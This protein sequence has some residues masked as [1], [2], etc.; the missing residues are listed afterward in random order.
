MSS[1]SAPPPQS[2]IEPGSRLDRYELLCVLAHGGMANVWLARVQGKLGF[3]KFFAVKTILPNV[4]E[5]P[6]FKD[7]FLDEARIASR[8]EHPNVVHISDVG[9]FANVPYLVMDLVEGEPLYKLP[10][11]CEKANT[12]LPLGIV[13]RI[14]ADACH[15]LHAAHEL[16]DDAGNLLNVVHRDMSPQ[17]ILVSTSGVSKVIDFGVAKARDRATAQTSAGTLKGKISYMPREQALGK[18]VDRRADTWALG[19]VLYYLLA[20]RPPYK[21]DNQLATLQL[22]MNGAP[23]P[24]LPAPIPMSLRTLVMRALAHEPAQ[25]FQTAAEMGTALEELMRK[26][27]IST[28]HANV[29]QFVNKVL[30]D[31]LESRKALITSAVNEASNRER[32]REALINVPVDLESGDDQGSLQEGL[33]AIPTAIISAPRLDSSPDDSHPRPNETSTA[34]TFVAPT[35]MMQPKP[36]WPLVLGAVVATLGIVGVVLVGVSL[37]SRGAPHTVAKGEAR[38]TTTANAQPSP[39]AV[40]E[41]AKAAPQAVATPEPPATPPTTKPSASTSAKAAPPWA[42]WAPAPAA[43]VK[44]AATTAK[45]A[46]TKKQDDEAGF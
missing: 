20:G 44:P 12:R 1:S 37:R 17:N 7:M 22:V 6:A 45:A 39:E 46:A 38:P 13:L 23:I 24:A 27:S 35:E 33:V 18:D 16:R 19:A 29:A 8:I 34:G 28:T 10:R 15:G 43:S 42:K 26:L 25:R 11:A 30:G 32:V 21:E 40:H 41:A 31:K 5:D 2:M 14:L 36:K 4:A 3:N 9:E